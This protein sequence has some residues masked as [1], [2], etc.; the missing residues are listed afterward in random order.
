MVSCLSEVLYLPILVH[1][2]LFLS[3]ISQLLQLI[4]KLLKAVGGSLNVKAQCHVKSVDLKVVDIDT[5]GSIGPS[6]GSISNQ[7]FE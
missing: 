1:I 7:R 4:L 5:Q 6:K 3:F 2:Y